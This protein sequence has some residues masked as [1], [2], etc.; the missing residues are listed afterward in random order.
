MESY[1]ISNM[2]I[3][4]NYKRLKISDDVIIEKKISNE[5]STKHGVLLVGNK[6]FIEQSISMESKPSEDPCN[7][8]VLASQNDLQEILKHLQEIE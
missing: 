2:I 6:C 5:K 7:I 4:I 8:I 3:P 1:I